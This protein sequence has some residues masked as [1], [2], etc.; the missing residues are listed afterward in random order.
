[1]MNRISE[2]HLMRRSAAALA[3]VLI[4]G[5]AAQPPRDRWHA[6]LGPNHCA[7]RAGESACWDCI[8]SAYCVQ[9]YQC[10]GNAGCKCYFPCRLTSSRAFC[11]SHCST[12]PTVP[13]YANELAECTNAHCAIACSS[14][15]SWP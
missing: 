10:E 1:M 2:R 9:L 6:L 14:E 13:G 12:G 11:S 8:R 5:C 4:A 7:P 15:A 3:I